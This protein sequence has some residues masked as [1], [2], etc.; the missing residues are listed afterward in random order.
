M[1]RI[2]EF[3]AFFAGLA[4]L[5]VAWPFVDHTRPLL[6]IAV[7]AAFVVCAG[8]YAVLRRG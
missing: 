4:I 5:V 6:S 3:V 8:T 1:R 7:I 2:A